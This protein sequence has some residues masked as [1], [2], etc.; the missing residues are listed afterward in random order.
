MLKHADTLNKVS[1]AKTVVLVTYFGALVRSVLIAF[2]PLFSVL[3]A[4]L[5]AILL[6]IAQNLDVDALWFGGL[7]I[8]ALCGVAA[9]WG[10]VAFQMPRLQQ[11][12][13]AVDETLPN[14]ALSALLDTEFTHTTPQND[15]Q[16]EF[17]WARHRDQMIS[18]AKTAKPVW[19]DL[20]LSRRDPY[21]LRYLALLLCLV[22]ILFGSTSRLSQISPSQSPQ[23]TAA[24]VLWEGW[25]IPPEYTKRPT[26]YLNDLTDL[27]HINVLENSRVQIRL[28][29]QAGDH[30]VEET[31]SAR[32]RDVPIASA[33][34]QEFDVL[35][36]GTLAI[37]G[38]NGAMWNIV[39]DHDTAPQIAITRDFETDFFGESALGLHG[40]DDFGVTELS[41]QVALDL[42][43]V[44]RRY[45]LVPDPDFTQVE[46][47]ELS[48]PPTGRAQDFDIDWIEDHSQSAMAHLP[49]TVT[50]RVADILGQT[51]ETVLQDAVLPAR[52][53]FDPIAS[54]LIEMRRDLMWSVQN[55]PR[56][57]R[58]IRAI[59][60]DP[61]GAFRSE[62]E[63]LRLRVFLR[64]LERSVDN[65]VLAEKRN[66]FARILW[67]MAIAMEEGDVNDALD[68]MRQAQER[69]S[70]AMKDGASDAEIEKLMQELRQANE[71][72]IR[73]L[74]QQAERDKQSQSQDLAQTSPQD[75]M[76]MNQ[77]DL[78]KM[79][80][81][82]QELMEQ[83]RMAEAQ[84]AL[85]E[86]Q[87]M[88]ENMQL[89]QGENGESGQ[90]DG[91]DQLSETLRDQQD[92]S[93]DAF[94][95]LQRGEPENDPKTDPQQGSDLAQRQGQLGQQLDQGRKALP[96]LNSDTAKQA[97]RSLDDAARAMRRAQDAL[98]AGDLDRAIDN[99]AQ[100]MDALRDG[101]RDM[102][103]AMAEARNPDQGQGMAQDQDT[104]N[105]RDPLGRP[106][107]RD[108]SSGTPEASQTTQDVA[109]QAEE[110]LNEIRRRAGELNRSELERGYLKRLLDLF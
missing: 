76:N 66:D 52:K 82:I 81:R 43:R 40:Q 70:Q 79:M 68:R 73:Q 42:P 108:G 93:D 16:I 20:D 25:V 65:G 24:A 9:I 94:R 77:S 80:D 86:L 48:L 30:L 36:A 5:G 53:F 105:A 12:I 71:N 29:G 10:A 47:F 18:E 4:C 23:T 95:E 106:Q 54:S 7:A 87:R 8:G 92:L 46:D 69:L 100:A 1:V 2:W 85:D 32:T 91:L 45:G 107:G 63:Y 89:A 103:R 27:D 11:A 98:G 19:P 15:P 28:Y 64:Q 67:D 26:L 72:Y 78:D 34:T 39:L 96:D 75:Q 44:S 17:L 37:V 58:M 60:Y 109:R 88:M 3:T 62:T 97:E 56:V 61:Q 110:L 6:G 35:N 22:G 104:E 50:L 38:A 101:I 83:G 31:V 102:D 14:R 74:R 33:M 49:I 55:G 59:T 51:G 99:Q 84:Q 57:A 21:A 13:D 90:S 41:G